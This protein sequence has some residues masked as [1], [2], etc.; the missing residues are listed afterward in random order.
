MEFDRKAYF[1]VIPDW[2]VPEQVDTA[3]TYKGSDRCHFLFN[4]PVSNTGRTL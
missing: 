3:T 2:L 1:A 4:I